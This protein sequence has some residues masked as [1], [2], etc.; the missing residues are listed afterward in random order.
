MITVGIDVGA[1]NVKIVLLK[2]GQ[3]A[4]K[5]KSIME[6]DRKKSIR[7][8]FDS[9]LSD[10]GVAES[11]IDS[12]VATGAG[13]KSAV[14]AHKGVT[15]VTADAAGIAKL[16]PSVRTV[17][18]VGANEAR[19]IRI[20]ETGKVIDFAINEK[21]AAGSGAFVE[22]MARAM[23]VS[24]DEFIDLSLQSTKVIPINA[25]CAIFAESE[26][27]SL[28]HEETDRND[29]C[30]AVHDAMTGR[31]ASMAK[32]VRIEAPVAFIGGVAYNR[33]MVDALGKDLETNLVVVDSPEYVGAYGAAQLAAKMA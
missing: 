4:A 1:K 7:D 5:F 23:E 20:D 19:A 29:I 32:R 3:V 30:R 6:M 24:L 18:D 31:I 2:D 22:A 9:C 33:A 27:V 14:F 17:L 16:D 13:Q 28:I 26:V 12:I 21:C 15:V 25:Q 11:D 10:G 8:A